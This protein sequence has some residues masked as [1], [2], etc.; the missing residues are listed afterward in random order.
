M[1]DQT[2]PKRRFNIID[3]LVIVFL[4]ATVVTI[5]LRSN[6]ETEI[7]STDKPTTVVLE[8]EVVAAEPLHDALT[9]GTLLLLSESGISFGTV[10][11]T[12]TRVA[13]NQEDAD[14]QTFKAVYRITADGA[15]G[16]KGYLLES[17]IPVAPNETFSL[18]SNLAG[19][20]DGLVLSVSSV[21]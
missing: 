18:K 17:G 21:S 3:F 10:T 8:L 13:D 14:D 6:L 1:H 11:E 15:I 9:K 19:P 20:F 16:N 2:A 7:F 12:G 4:I 5:V